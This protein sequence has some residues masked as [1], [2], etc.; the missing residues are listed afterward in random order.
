M[1][2]QDRLPTVEFCGARGKGSLRLWHH[3]Q[4]Q[5]DI[6]RINTIILGTVSVAKGAKSVDIQ[7][8]KVAQDRFKDEVQWL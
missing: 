7:C 5:W 4:T 2:V 8:V 6:F 1:F 3:G